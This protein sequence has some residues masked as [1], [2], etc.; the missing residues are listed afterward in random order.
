MSRLRE[1]RA[2]SRGRRQTV[3]R[4]RV[5]AA[6]LPKA[7]LPSRDARLSVWPHRHGACP[8]PRGREDAL[9]AE[10]HRPS[11][12]HQV[13]RFDTPIPPREGVSQSRHSGLAQHDV[14]APPSWG[15]RARAPLQGRPRVRPVCRRC[16][17]RRD[18]HAP[19]RSCRPLLSLELHHPGVG[20]LQV[21]AEPKWRRP[22][23]GPRAVAGPP[24]R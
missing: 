11:H 7:H 24:R 18:E 20:R 17:R 9:R 19:A 14:R 3:D 21:R 4:L 23:G 5:R 22:Q 16:A 10:L 1:H 8:G 12:R 13:R 6:S 2:S 15:H